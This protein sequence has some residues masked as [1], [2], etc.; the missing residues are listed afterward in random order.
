MYGK[1][2]DVNLRLREYGSD[3]RVINV[4]NAQ[5]NAGHTPA[6]VSNHMRFKKNET[7]LMSAVLISKQSTWISFTVCVVV[8]SDMMSLTLEFQR[9]SVNDG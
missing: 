7:S 2:N 1:I 8:T 3:S 9:D 6:V 4:W 5:R